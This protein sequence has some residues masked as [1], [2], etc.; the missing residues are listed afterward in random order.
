VDYKAIGSSGLVVSRIGLGC[1]NI[2][3][4]IDEEQSRRVIHK[5]LGL[6][7]TLFDVADEYGE[8]F[9]NTERVVGKILKEMRKDVVIVTKFGLGK[10]LHPDPRPVARGSRHYVMRA[11]EDSLTRLGTDYIDV[12]MYHFPDPR[13][14]IEET[15]RALDDIVR[16]GKARYIACSNQAGWQ[17]VQAY[18]VAR[19]LRTHHFIASENHYSL[20]NR[21]MEKDLIPALRAVGMSLLPFFPLENGMLTGKYRRGQPAAEGDRLGADIFRQ[22]NRLFTDRNFDIVENLSGFCLQRGHSLAELALAWLLAQ[23]A[24]PAVCAGATKPEQ[25]EQNVK[26]VD[27]QLGDEDLKTVNAITAPASTGIVG[28]KIVASTDK[29]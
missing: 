6:G 3:W 15:L 7:I 8:P 20:L 18:W 14:P 12:Y 17:A 9:G 29:G 24:I 5:A 23:P 11:V 19:E 1:N 2:G 22:R 10:W 27:W 21:Q 26:A 13:T 4:T 28:E 16:S 25:V